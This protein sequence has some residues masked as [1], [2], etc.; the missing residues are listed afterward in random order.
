MEYPT[1]RMTLFNLISLLFTYSMAYK[2]KMSASSHSLTS[3]DNSINFQKCTYKVDN[4]I[5]F[6]C[7]DQA[8]MWIA[9]AESL[10]KTDNCVRNCPMNQLGSGKV[11]Y[12]E[13]NNQMAHNVVTDYQVSGYSVSAVRNDNSLF[14]SYLDISQFKSFNSKWSSPRWYN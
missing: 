5:A 11:D 2:M 6:S 12:I 4:L 7:S 9:D 13:F 10:L 14:L 3:I 1:C 8:G